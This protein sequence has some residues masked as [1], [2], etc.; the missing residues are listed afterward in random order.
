MLLRATLCLAMS[1][2]TA[3]ALSCRAPD[4]SAGYS[5]AMKAPES[6]VVVDGRISYDLQIFG[7][8]KG[9][10]TS[11]GDR[12]TARMVGKRLGRSGFTTPFASEIILVA[13]CVG[14]WC[15]GLASGE[16]YTAFLRET[17][18]KLELHLEPCAYWVFPASNKA[19]KRTIER[20]HVQGGCGNTKGR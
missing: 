6:Y 19:V 3:S 11:D 15:G 20:C 18:G 14:R 13:H 16:R 12:T 2:S 8:G 4:A 17:A 10:K 1:A 7:S 5:R 9:R